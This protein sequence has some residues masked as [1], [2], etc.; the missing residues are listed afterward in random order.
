MTG[1][2]HNDT[3]NWWQVL[4]TKALPETGRGRVVRNQ[5]VVQ[6]RHVKTQTNL[7]THDVASPLMPTNQ[8]FTTISPADHDRYN[9]TLFI[10]NIFDGHSGQEW[11]TKSGHFR[12][13]HVPTK[14]SLWTHPEPLPEWAFNQQEI[15]GNKAANDRSFTWVVEDIIT[16]ERR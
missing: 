1:Y 2:P 8:E 15:N 6:L 14:V 7:L 11:K 4:P 13:Q 12:L 9:D 3:N 5:D 16:D 10:I